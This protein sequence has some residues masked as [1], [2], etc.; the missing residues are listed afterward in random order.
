M[1][2]KD[3]IIKLLIPN[4][5]GLLLTQNLNKIKLT[6]LGNHE[7]ATYF[8]FELTKYRNSTDKD[9]FTLFKY[10]FWSHIHVWVDP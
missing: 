3:K 2:N 8:L 6:G 7:H 1:N 5:L 4:S 10:S 9:D